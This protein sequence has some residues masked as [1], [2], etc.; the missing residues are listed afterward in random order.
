M[1]RF[2]PRRRRRVEKIHLQPE[3]YEH[4]SASYPLEALAFTLC[5][6]NF[7]ARSLTDSSPSSFVW[8][9]KAISDCVEPNNVFS[10]TLA[11]LQWCRRRGHVMVSCERQKVF[12]FV[13]FLLYSEAQSRKMQLKTKQRRIEFKILNLY[14][15]R[16]K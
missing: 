6:S 14:I 1:G 15:D 10:F 4:L 8:Q 3:E 12:S 9:K 7:N 2:L 5:C 11:L 13:V 16:L